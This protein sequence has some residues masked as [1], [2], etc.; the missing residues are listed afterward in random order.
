MPLILTSNC[1]A[2][3]LPNRP[4]SHTH[5]EQHAVIGSARSSLLEKMWLRSNVQTTLAYCMLDYSIKFGRV[6]ERA[7]ML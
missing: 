6:C 3:V 4:T 7:A 2:T 5:R 1:Q